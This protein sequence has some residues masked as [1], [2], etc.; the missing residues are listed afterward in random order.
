MRMLQRKQ[1][2]AAATAPGS[3]VVKAGRLT[4]PHN[5]VIV[6]G[7]SIPDLIA[8]HI[9]AQYLASREGGAK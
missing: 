8:L 6:S 9:G 5:L 2:G 3:N 4:T 7:Q 1:A